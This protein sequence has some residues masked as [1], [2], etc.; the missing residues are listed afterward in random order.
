MKIALL[1]WGS[2]GDVNPFLALGRGLQDAGHQPVLCAPSPYR[3]QV[4]RLGLPYRQI[5]SD[6]EPEE[7]RE[8]MLGLGR[9]ARR[10]VKQLQALFERGMLRDMDRLVS[11]CVQAVR[12][13]HDGPADLVVSHH[14]LTAGRIAAEK[15]HTPWVTV[16]LCPSTIPISSR[17]PRGLPDL[18]PR[19]NRRLWHFAARMCRRRIDPLLNASRVAHGLLPLTNY[20]MESCYSP[21]L[22]LVAVSRHLPLGQEEWP[23]QHQL[24]G[25]LSLRETREWQPPQA[26]ADFLAAGP[27][28]VYVGFGSMMSAD[29]ARLSRVVLAALDESG[30]RGVLAAGWG[31]LA[32]GHAPG[33]VFHVE[34]APHGWLFP[35][36]A[37]VVHHGG[38]GTVAGGL[39]AGKPTVVCTFLAEQPYWGKLVHEVGV[40]PRPIPLRK[41]TASRLAPAIRTAVEDAQMRQ[42]AQQLGRKIDAE[43]GVAE[44]V[45]LIEQAV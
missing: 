8:T 21:L 30:Q 15:L 42:A 24:T 2:T 14:I 37:A 6:W 41:L 20:V 38:A 34:W 12:S 28:P 27:P 39:R 1:T 35:R 26:L 11:D 13:A 32:E 10:P 19:V 23:R 17:P 36:M 25:F 5:G 16:T 33:T 40:G 22:N 29:P 44:A 18:G 43:D 3:D 9:H 4:E 45:R 31:G 7:V